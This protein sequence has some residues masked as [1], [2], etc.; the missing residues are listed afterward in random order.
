MEWFSWKQNDS[1]SDTGSRAQSPVS[2]C[3]RT[4]DPAAGKRSGVK[5]IMNVNGQELTQYLYFGNDDSIVIGTEMID[6]PGVYLSRDYYIYLCIN[7]DEEQDRYNVIW[8]FDGPFYSYPRGESFTY[9]IDT[10]VLL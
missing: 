4:S 2:G 9:G 6:G 10:F 5:W 8:D 1:L 3:N 7:F